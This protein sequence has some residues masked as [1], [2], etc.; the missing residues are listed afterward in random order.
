MAVLRAVLS[1][2]LYVLPSWLQPVGISQYLDTQ[3]Q[4]EEKSS[5]DFALWALCGGNNPSPFGHYLCHSAPCQSLLYHRSDQIQDLIRDPIRN[6]S[7]L[8]KINLLFRIFLAHLYPDFPYTSMSWFSLHIF[9]P[10]F[11]AHQCPD[12]QTGLKQET[13]NIVLQKPSYIYWRKIN[14]NNVL[15]TPLL[16]TGKSETLMTMQTMVTWSEQ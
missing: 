11:L 2:S 4:L 5:S 8:S 10:D 15:Q 16:I 14:A 6:R 3:C 7:N 9:I 1:F 13:N 12:F